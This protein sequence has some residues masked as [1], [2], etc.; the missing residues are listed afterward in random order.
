MPLAI[1]YLEESRAWI[2]VEHGYE[3]KELRVLVADELKDFLAPE[4]VEHVLE[5]KGHNAL[6][7]GI[8]L[9]LL[10]GDVFLDRKL[11]CLYHEVHVTVDANGAVEG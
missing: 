4:L 6:R 5:V 10:V 2:S 8:A 11:G 9:F 1:I 3:Q 7:W